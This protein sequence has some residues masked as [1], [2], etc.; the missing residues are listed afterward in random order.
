[1]KYVLILFVASSVVLSG[2]FPI[3]VFEDVTPL[4]D[5]ETKGNDE[6]EVLATNFQIPWSIEKNGETFFIS[7]RNGTIAKVVNGDLTRQKV[8]LS[9]DLSD[10]SEAGLLGFVLAPDFDS[11]QKAFAYYTYEENS[12]QFNRIVELSL[13]DN[14]WTETSILVDA[15]PSGNVHHGG[16][17]AIGPDKKLYAT[18]GDASTPD[19]AQDVDSLAGKILRMNVDGSIP[20]DNPFNDSYVYS[21]GHRNPQ[22]LVWAEDGTMYASEHGQAANDEINKIEPGKNYGWPVI[23]GRD[24]EEGM[25]TPIFTS[26]SDR[27]WAPSGMALHDNILYVAALRGTTVLAFDIESEMYRAVM[28]DVGR[29]RDVMIADDYLYFISN[30]TDG[31]GTPSET[32]DKFYRVKLDE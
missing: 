4:T 25:I 21:Y 23:E 29:V 11:S 7:E 10:A 26:G 20:E 24:E 27:T 6:L 16:R 31:R 9:K 18:A 22:G 5:E 15:I 2:C 28:E 17:L 32:D 12:S 14:T 13:E 1:M 3:N 30:N 19:L 8:I